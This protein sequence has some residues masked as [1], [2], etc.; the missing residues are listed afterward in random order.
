MTE[1]SREHFLSD[2]GG[3]IRDP[4]PADKVPLD[5]R[6]CRGGKLGAVENGRAACKQCS[7]VHGLLRIKGKVSYGVLL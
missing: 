5:C 7:R 3:I 2:F 6:N 4:G 1:S